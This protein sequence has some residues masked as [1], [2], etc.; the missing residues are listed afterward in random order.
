MTWPVA[1]FLALA[2]SLAL[3]LVG[4]IAALLGLQI[5]D[6]IARAVHRVLA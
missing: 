5:Y 6:A 3:G 1:L 2:S 4:A